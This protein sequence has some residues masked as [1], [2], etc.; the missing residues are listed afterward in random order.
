[1]H[2]FH[3]VRGNLTCE[4]IKIEELVR[5][6]GTPLYVYSYHTL[7]SHYL[8]LKDAFGGI[9][10]LI[11]YSVKA[12]SN[13]AIL[14]ALV[15]KGAGLDIVSGGELFRAVKAG[16]PAEKIV[17]ASV[18]KTD[19]EIEEAV[20]RGI[21]FFNVESAAEL[22]NI[23]RIAGTLNRRVNVAV[24][25]NPDVEPKTHKFITTGK[26]T[27]KF[28]ID[29]KTAEKI[30]MRCCSFPNVN[31]KGLHIHIGSQI[32]ESAPYVAAVTR[33]VNFI[34]RLRK[35][36]LTME[37]LN[38][39]GGLGI[40][41]DK[42]TPQTAKKFADKIIPLLRGKSLKIIL[43][44]GRFIAGNAGILVT[45]VL[46]LKST[47]KKKFVIVDAGMNDLVRP[48]LYDAY[49]N[50]L[51]LHLSE[52]DTR[53]TQKADVVGP[54]CESGDFFAKSRRMPRVQ[55]GDYLAIMSAGA[56]GFSMSSNYN[57][58]RRAEEVLVIKDQSFVIRKRES[59]EDLVHNESIPAF[60][61][62]L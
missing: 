14:K 18:G 3:Y 37:Y 16:C 61:F 39:G 5:R 40:I 57:S 23:N 7:I 48:A 25:I 51:P 33:I 10:P 31:I 55:E 26:I 29:F 35:K 11:C 38:I 36:G 58:R 45:R 19:A 49:H 46:Y 53:M 34:E 47:P 17:Y 4:E 22:E 13:L 15:D 24:R 44:P 41:Y 8:K 32:T 30:L 28:G 42:E 52:K 12:N 50:I 54:I 21:L 9:D 56:Y 62:G 6:F 60:L 27:D 2:E 43:E 20:R 1:M 59:W